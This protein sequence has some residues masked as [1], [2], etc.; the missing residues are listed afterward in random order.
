[1]IASEVVEKIQLNAEDVLQ[2]LQ[3]RLVKMEQ[4]LDEVTSLLKQQNK[5]S[6]AIKTL[7][8]VLAPHQ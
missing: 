5:D 7:R 1:M 2:K 6:S 3:E 8:E 4:K